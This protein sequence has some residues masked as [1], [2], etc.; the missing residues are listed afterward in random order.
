MRAALAIAV[1][2]D[3]GFVCPGPNV[4]AF[5]RKT[6]P[7]TVDEPSERLL[8][9]LRRTAPDEIAD[10]V[11]TAVTTFAEL[12]EDVFEDPAFV[13]AIAE[14]DQFVVDECGYQTVDVTMA[15]DSFEGIPARL[16]TGVVAFS[17]RNEG[18]ELHE[19]TVGKL[20]GDATLDDILEL[21]ADASEK[22]T[23]QADAAGSGRRLCVPRRIRCRPDRLQEVW[24]GRGAVLHSGLGPHPKRQR[25]QTMKPRRA[26]RAAPCTLTKVWRSSSTS[27]ADCTPAT[28][29]P[30]TTEHGIVREAALAEAQRR[31]GRFY[32]RPGSRSKDLIPGDPPV[33][34]VLERDWRA[35][36][37]NQDTNVFAA[38]LDAR[39][40]GSVRRDA[41]GSRAGH[42]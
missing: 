13:A 5:C 25:Q 26:T 9:R 19:L 30:P 22:V 24:Q 3:N 16:D 6:W 12:G 35:S 39:D 40:V 7:S 36:V 18:V 15:D 10:T 14:I 31:R 23:W 11:D 8:E 20:K 41:V 33:L 34:D 17:L 38:V 37:T 29:C 27:R 1:V 42:R 28:G 21:P 2:A 32:A 4:K